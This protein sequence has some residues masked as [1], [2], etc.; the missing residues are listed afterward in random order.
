MQGSVVRTAE[1]NRIDRKPLPSVAALT[2]N[3]EPHSECDR[4][5]AARAEQTMW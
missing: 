1:S 5:W 2:S 3:K 4:A